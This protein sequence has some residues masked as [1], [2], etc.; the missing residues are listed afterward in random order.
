MDATMMKRNLHTV[1]IYIPWQQCLENASCSL[2]A[3]LSIRW[4]KK[5]LK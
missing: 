5:I 1:A 3:A 4:Q 2:S